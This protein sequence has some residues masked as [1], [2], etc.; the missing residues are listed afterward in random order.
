MAE[1]IN[2]ISAAELPE[3]TGEEISVLCLENG[4]M[5][6][7]PAN[8]LGGGGF[9]EVEITLSGYDFY[10]GTV[11]FNKTYNEIKDAMEK[12][13]FVM[14]WAKNQQFTGEEYNY[15]NAYLKQMF[16]KYAADING[17]TIFFIF[18]NNDQFAYYIRADGTT[19][20]YN[21]NG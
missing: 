10:S 19:G 3:A 8:G 4:A 17:G 9:M 12:G 18:T 1:N 6:Q 2:F 13:Y 14:G 16:P 15:N 11:T 5:K 7:K 21:T 20:I